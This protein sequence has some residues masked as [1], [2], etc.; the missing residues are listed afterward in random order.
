MSTPSWSYRFAIN[1]RFFVT[2]FAYERNPDELT[3]NDLEKTRWTYVRPTRSEGF[4]HDV[5][6]EEDHVVTQ[7]SFQILLS[8]GVVRRW[9]RLCHGDERF[10]GFV[11]EGHTQV[12]TC[13]G[14]LYFML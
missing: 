10:C 5:I 7:K 4:T 12:L 2:S 8:R 6:H 14:Y 11:G 3:T 13:G 9:D 1:A